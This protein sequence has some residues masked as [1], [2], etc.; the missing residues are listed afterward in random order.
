MVSEQELAWKFSEEKRKTCGAAD[1]CDTCCSTCFCG[2]VVEEWYEYR[3]KHR[4]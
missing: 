1:S 2:N 4:K 3:S